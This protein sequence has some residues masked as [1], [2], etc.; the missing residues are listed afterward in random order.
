M[1]KLSRIIGTAALLS[2]LGAFPAFAAWKQ[3]GDIWKYT[4]EQGKYA[5]NKW[6]LI[7]GY[8]YH[9]NKDQEMETGWI[10]LKKKWYYLDPATGTMRTGWFQDTD[11]KWYYLD[12]E[13]GNMLKNKRT[14]DGYY[15]GEDGYYDAQLDTNHSGPGVNAVTGAKENSLKGVVFPDLKEFATANL[16]TSTW[17]VE[18]SQEALLSLGAVLAQELREE[19]KEVTGENLF[20]IDGTSIIFAV[21]GKEKP[22][23]KLLK[24][25][26]H[27]ELYD[28]ESIDKPMESALMA[29]CSIISSQPQLAYNAMY[30]AAQYDQ[31][32]MASGYYKSFG[33][34]Q[35]KYT[36]LDKHFYFSIIGK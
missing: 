22:L 23:L 34:S 10:L 8:W 19:G 11:G 30:T 13:K 5:R 6:A 27:Y 20:Y 18:G 33:D 14:P 35:I 32:V 21:E 17:G 31:T 9:F 28:Y 25:G 15:I 12:D 36:I 3:Q 24:N 29:M 2:I 7:D 1:R 16:E 4:D 26:D